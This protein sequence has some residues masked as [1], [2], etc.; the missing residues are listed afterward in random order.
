[1]TDIFLTE[2]QTQ[3]LFKELLQHLALVFSCSRH[4]TYLSTAEKRLLLDGDET[5]DSRPVFKQKLLGYP[6]GP[7]IHQIASYFV[8]LMT[9]GH[10]PIE[11]TPPLI[12]FDEKNYHDQRI[13][14]VKLV[15]EQLQ[16]GLT[17]W[18]HWRVQQKVQ[19]LAGVFKRLRRRGLLD[20]LQ[21]RRTVGS[22]DRLPIPRHLLIRA[23][24]ELND[25]SSPLTVC[26][27]ALTKHTARDSTGWWGPATGSDEAK[28][29]NG[30][31]KVKE[32]LDNAVWINIHQLPGAVA[33][34]EI[35]IGDG[36]G[37]RFDYDPLRFRGFVE[38]HQ[39]EGWLNR[40]KH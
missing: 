15:Q 30:I 39:T 34:L 37:V 9:T 36:H 1:M 28:N 23:C 21:L 8:L 18:E 32:I 4:V 40:Y 2:K 35:R 19:M 29:E 5:S 14:T 24:E 22:V 7:L 27:R 11:H 33:N 31:R 26:G 12:T 10:C 17:L 38:P 6:E 3:R 13:A 16:G 20:L 25:P